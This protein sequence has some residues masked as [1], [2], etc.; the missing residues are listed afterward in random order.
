MYGGNAWRRPRQH[1]TWRAPSYSKSMDM[2]FSFGRETTE[3]E[4]LKL[5][6]DSG[7]I[8]VSNTAASIRGFKIG[9]NLHNGQ[10]MVYCVKP[11]LSDIFV[12]KLLAFAGDRI[13]KC[14][15]YSNNEIPVRFSFI[16]PSIDIKK[17]IID[18]HLVKYGQVKEWSLIRDKKYGVPTG[19]VIFIMKEE[20][21]RENPLPESI[22][23]NHMYCRISYRTQER[24]CFECRKPGHLA[25]NCPAIHFPS[26]GGS[27][28]GQNTTNSPFLSGQLP[29]RQLST[30]TVTNVLDNLAKSS[31]QNA[32]SSEN[33]VALQSEDTNNSNV[34]SAV[35]GPGETQQSGGGDDV[36]GDEISSKFPDVEQSDE[37]VLNSDDDTVTT[38]VQDDDGGNEGKDDGKSDG[39]AKDDS[40]IEDHEEEMEGDG[41]DKDGSGMEE[42]DDEEAMEIGSGKRNRKRVLKKLLAERTKERSKWYDGGK[43]S[44]T[45]VFP[46]INP[47]T[48]VYRI[49][50]N[51]NS[52]NN[53]ELQS[54]SSS[55]VILPLDSGNEPKNI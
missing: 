44:R 11:G 42:N 18:A 17:D 34:S 51:K 28:Q 47:D 52:I 27:T 29:K 32:A 10:V 8:D 38:E 19:A 55:N 40:D 2:T 53:V 45:K 14:H 30:D 23:I 41:T 1:D 24:I 15:S 9:S 33:T 26:M 39:F 43:G 35:N 20:E 16:H 22:F 50:S 21:L 37:G 31:V 12:E 49:P 13:V 4:V 36:Q 6:H 54:S 7:C 48:K 46:H 3:L 25:K 5:L